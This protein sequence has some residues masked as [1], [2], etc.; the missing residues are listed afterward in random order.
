MD[1]LVG[2]HVE[3]INSGR[4]GEMTNKGL[5]ISYECL[6]VDL[7]GPV[8]EENIFVLMATKSYFD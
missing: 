7:T 3:A 2:A 1:V 5:K 8:G 6:Q 4:I